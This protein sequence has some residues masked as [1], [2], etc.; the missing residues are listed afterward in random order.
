[1][2]VTFKSKAY[3]DVTMFGDVALKLIRIMGHSGTVPGAI[4]TDEIRLS[5]DRL[6]AAVQADKELNAGK[7]E[8]PDDAKESSDRVSLSQRAVPLIEML[9]AAERLAAPVMWGS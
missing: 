9:E 5:L 4:G 7:A 2:L 1:M 3:G 6:R 8:K